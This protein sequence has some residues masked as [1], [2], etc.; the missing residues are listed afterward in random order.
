MRKRKIFSVL[1]LLLS[2]GYMARTVKIEELKE[3][4]SIA[5][6]K[7]LSLSFGM[8]FSSILIS[9]LRWYIALREVQ[10][11]S[12]RKTFTAI[13]SGFYMMVFLPPS[14]GHLAKVKLVG[15]DYFKALSALIFG[16]SLEGLILVIISIVAFGTSMWKFLLLGLL[17]VPIFYDNATY[18]VLQ[19]GLHLVR[20]ISPRL[21]RRLEDYV[22][23]IHFGWRN[24]KKNPSTFAVLLFLSA[25]AV[26]LQVGG[27]ITVGKA[28]GLSVGLLDAIKAFILSTLFAVVSGIPSGIGANELG[29]TLALGS[30][31]KSTLVA[32]TYKFIYQYAWSFVGAVEF[33]KTV[34]GKS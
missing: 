30:S 8:A 15:G 6:L 21:A 27:I 23:R 32:F 17:L 19:V 13:L 4:F 26:L 5:D 33:Y 12:F 28:F 14:V 20:R 2:L 10:D 31:T 16:I 18:N 9:T 22:E 24:S 7:L 25:L 29:I 3:A 11:A 1:L 34:G